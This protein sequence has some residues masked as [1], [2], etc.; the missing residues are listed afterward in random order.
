[1]LTAP[2]PS[3]GMSIYATL[4]RLRFPR[5]GDDHT[6]C[7]WVEVVAQG[8]P[9]HIGT[10]TPGH[11]YKDGEPYGTF[12][13]PPIAIDND[14]DTLSMR[15]VVFVTGESAKGTKRSPQEYVNPLLVLTGVEYERLPFAEIHERI[16]AALRGARPRLVAEFLTPDGVTR[17][18]F[19][20]GTQREVSSPPQE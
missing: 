18:H 1:M 5:Y 6:G 16:C 11:G 8:V 14:E 17:L 10:P 7:E 3:Q 20:N 2:N 9:A 15:A 13:P 19:E 4:W 12:L